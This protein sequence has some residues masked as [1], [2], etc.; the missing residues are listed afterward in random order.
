MVAFVCLTLIILSVQEKERD[1]REKEKEVKEKDKKSPNGHQ[2]TAVI[3]GPTAQCSQCNKAFNS[4]GGFYCASKCQQSLLSFFFFF[5]KS[6][7]GFLRLT[8]SPVALHLI[9]VNWE[10]A[11]FKKKKKICRSLWSFNELLFLL[12]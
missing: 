10:H 3:L 8:R 4:K 5:N 1:K 7:L 12:S 11:L 9:R 2:F 6:S